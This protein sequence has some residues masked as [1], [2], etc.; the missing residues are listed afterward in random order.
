MNTPRTLGAVARALLP[1]LAATAAA[2]ASPAAAAVSAIQGGADSQTQVG[3]GAPDTVKFGP[4]DRTDD[5][6]ADPYV[7]SR[8]DSREDEYFARV[9]DSSGSAVRLDGPNQAEFFVRSSVDANAGVGDPQ[10]QK[11]AHGAASG[12]A[13]YDFSVDTASSL[14]F[15]LSAFF[16][17]ATPSVNAYVALNLFSYDTHT[18]LRQGYVAGS[19]TFAYT[20]PVGS[21]GVTLTSFAEGAVP[22]DIRVDSEANGSAVA[23]LSLSVSAVSLPAPVPAV[24][25]PATWGLM[26]FGIGAVGMAHRRRKA[27]YF[28]A[29]S[30]RAGRMH[31]NA[32]A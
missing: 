10:F 24:P 19:E 21:Y 31:C 7:V 18:Y 26:L 23:N 32:S 27:T 11:R 15:A 17:S 4:S 8:S 20:V 6:A 14:S 25:E 1:L 16:S 30:V 12:S 28:R 22:A 13:F 5:V 9:I 2:A 29:V 3:V